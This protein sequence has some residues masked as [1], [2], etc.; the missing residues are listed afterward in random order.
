MVGTVASVGLARRGWRAL[1]VAGV[2]LCFGGALSDL[3]LV[4]A[5]VVL[6]LLLVNQYRVL[7]KDLKGFDTML[8]IPGVVEDTLI[9]GKGFVE[10]L[11]ITSQISHTVSLSTSSKREEVDPSE[12]QFGDNSVT[13]RFESPRSGVY[14]T[15]R[16]HAVIHDSF[17]LFQGTEEIG[18]NA[19]FN[20][21]PRVFPVAVRAIEYL[22]GGGYRGES[23]SPLLRGR[24]GEYAH[25]R[26]YVPGDSMKIF[27]WKAYARTSRPMVKEYY[28]EEGGGVGVLYDRVVS[29]A[30]SLDELNAEFLETVLGYIIAGAPLYLM[31]LE[32]GGVTTVSSGSQRDALVVAIQISLRGLITEF[33]EYYSVLD[34]VGQ[35][36]INRLLETKSTPGPNNQYDHLV[37]L[38][39]LQSNP[40]T[41]INTINTRAT[42]IQPTQPRLYTPDL[43]KAIKLYHDNTRKTRQLK[44]LGINTIKSIK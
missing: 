5:G 26:L 44:K 39:A 14:K 30:V 23:T 24:G 10:P 37:I 43:A 19:S 32:D 7:R 28:D 17:R 34:P 21:Y 40:A 13:Y 11:Q 1:V 18:F 12:I 36:K 41:I 35:A 9:A 38:S 16:L 33:F 15:T 25:S 42:I 20:V 4:G 31:T 3:V 2:L 29:D 6:L 22:L 8:V 27:D